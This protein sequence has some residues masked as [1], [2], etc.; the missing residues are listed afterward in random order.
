M[1]CVSS[2]DGLESNVVA[3][4]IP[5][6]LSCLAVPREKHDPRWDRYLETVRLWF[7]TGFV[8]IDTGKHFAH[9][10]VE[11]FISL[12]IELILKFQLIIHS[13]LL[14]Y[15]ASPV[16]YKLHLL[17]SLYYLYIILLLLLKL[18]FLLLIN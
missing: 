12:Y 16:N 15:N 7:R 9:F 8:Y 1:G 6:P 3:M 13:S 10:F 18:I 4:Y 5:E 2:P 17:F 14:K 11:C